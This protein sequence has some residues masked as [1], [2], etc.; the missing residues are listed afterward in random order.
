LNGERKKSQ[1]QENN[2]ICQPVAVSPC[3]TDA[4]CVEHYPFPHMEGIF[5][6]HEAVGRI[7]EVG[8]S[9]KKF[10]IGDVVVVPSIT[11]EWDAWEIQDGLSKFSNGSG[12]LFTQKKDGVFAEYFHVNDA[13]QNLALLPKNMTPIEG[14]MAVDMLATAC[15]GIEEAGI[16]FGDTVVIF[17][18]GPVGLLSI[19]AAKLKGAGKI[20]ALGT[21]AICTEL[22]IQ[23]GANEVIDYRQDKLIEKILQLNNNRPVDIVVTAGG[24]SSVISQALEIVKFGGT[25]SNVAGF[26]SDTETILSNKAWFL[27]TADKT[28]RGTMVPGGGRYMERMLAL[29]SSG[30]VDVTPLATPV[31]YGFNEIPRALEIMIHKPIDAI[32]PVVIIE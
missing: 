6:G 12:Y 2:V 22:A 15:A 17:G 18:I 11:P 19:V 32:K 10:Q 28:I 9:V 26:V 1:K 29:I 30:R 13:D 31:L 3:T 24:N 14:I 5:L 23:Y 8:P 4:H 20:I 27:G 21:R 7:T 25:V 16:Q